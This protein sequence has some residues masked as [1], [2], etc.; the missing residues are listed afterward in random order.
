[1]S[2]RTPH[3]SPPSRA[4]HPAHPGQKARF[5]VVIVGAGLVGASLALAL[6]RP[7]SGLSVALVDAAEPA[8]LQAD[9][10]AWDSRVYALS[11]GSVDFLAQLGA[12]QVIDP[13]RL[14]PV[15]AMR[16]FGDGKGSRLDFSAY[17]CAVAELAWIVESG[18]VQTALWQGLRSARSVALHCPARCVRLLDSENAIELDGGSILR[19]DLLVAADGSRSWL[20]QAAGIALDV[21]AYDQLGVV[22][23]F[24]CAYAHEG[25]ARQWFGE[26]GILAWLP[27]PGNRVSMVW[28]TPDAHARS[29]LAMA[30]DSFARCVSRAGGEA[31]GTMRLLGTP[32]AFPLARQIAAT[33]VR[34]GLALVGDAAHTVH[35]LA[36]QGVNL[37]FSDARVLAE[38]LLQRETVRSCGDLRLLRRYQR[39]RAED[40]LAMRLAT[41]ALARLFGSRAGAVAWLRN[42][43]LN[44]TAASPVL[45]TLLAR[46]ALG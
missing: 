23:N 13:Q 4:A 7:D 30:P 21:Q 42:T 40:I 35:P 25:I 16:V 39:A 14:S 27:L 37:G 6:S 44:L 3:T 5:D 11:P 26:Q 1:M 20:R 12:W 41:D 46:R 19:A 2:L 38:I 31:L 10:T 45:T 33:T 36:G 15:R 29:L 24:E 28:S 17:D 32:A 34:A 22:A 9:F 43:G 8:P 18:R